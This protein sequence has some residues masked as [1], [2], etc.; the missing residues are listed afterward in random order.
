MTTLLTVPVCD[1]PKS[2][3][4]PILELYPNAVFVID[5]NSEVIVALGITK[6]GHS[7]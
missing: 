5:Q 2:I 4:T 1:L 6:E 3:T 7:V